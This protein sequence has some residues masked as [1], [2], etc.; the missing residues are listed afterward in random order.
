M[1]RVLRFLLILMIFELGVLVAVLPW[2]SFWE[3]NYFLERF[4]ALLPFL[5]NPFVRGFISGL[6]VLDMGIAAG[7]VRRR[8]EPETT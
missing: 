8:K 4:P 5:L 7:M 6:G 3:R 1:N 2:S